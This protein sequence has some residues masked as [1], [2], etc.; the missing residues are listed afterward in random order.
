[1]KRF[2]AVVAM[3]LF[4]GCLLHAA[5]APARDTSQ[6]LVITHTERLDFPVG[7]MLRIQHSTG[8]LTVEGWDRPDVEITTTKSN[9]SNIDSAPAR[10]HA[11]AELDRVHIAAERKES[12]LVVTTD[13]PRRMTFPGIHALHGSAT[14][15]D[16][17]Y[18]IRAPRA[19]RVV[20]DHNEGEVFIDDIAGNI[21]AKS[22]QG[23]IVL[24]LTGD[25]P[26]YITANAIAGSVNSDFPGKD[27]RRGWLLGHGFVE[28]NSS[29]AQKLDLRIGYGD[30]VVLRMHNPQ[31]PAAM[32][33]SR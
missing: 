28:G 17:E 31:P 32:E 13:F 30:I 23:E 29:A 19:A 7:G 33:G 10:A 25:A 15:F 3:G 27:T 1:M 20:I 22:R 11:Q 16:L 5:E 26:R 6:K 14:S 4:A 12:D 2:K 9:K 24:H 8:N 21:Q 18:R